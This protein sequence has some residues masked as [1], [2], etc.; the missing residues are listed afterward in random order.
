MVGMGLNRASVPGNLL[1]EFRIRDTSKALKCL[2]LRL[3][4]IATSWCL[5]RKQKSVHLGQLALPVN[6][7]ERYCSPKLARHLVLYKK[8]ATWLGK[9]IKIT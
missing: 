5:P 7:S 2:R 9:K 3:D 4:T 1:G 6:I 8:N